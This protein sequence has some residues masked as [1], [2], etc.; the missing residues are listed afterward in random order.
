MISL[1]IEVEVS[2]IDVV[3]VVVL[4]GVMVVF[5]ITV[6]V[7]VWKIGLWNKFCSNIAKVIKRTPS[8][9]P[10]NRKIFIQITQQQL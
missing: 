4:S 8:M 10:A 6:S 3:F 9:K 2:T 5:V 7:V 1:V